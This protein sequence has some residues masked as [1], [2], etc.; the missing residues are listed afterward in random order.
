MWLLAWP[1][2]THAKTALRHLTLAVLPVHQGKTERPPQSEANAIAIQDSSKT[3][4]LFAGLAITLASPAQE[5][6][7]IIVPVV[8]QT[9]PLTEQTTI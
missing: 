7:T 3:V 6:T 2:T 1:V 9:A 8:L 4:F 5:E